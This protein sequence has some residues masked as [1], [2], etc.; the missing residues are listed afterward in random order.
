MKIKSTKILLKLFNGKLRNATHFAWSSMITFYLYFASLLF[1]DDITSIMFSVL[2]AIFIGFLKE[3]F[4]EI[5]LIETMI[6][7]ILGAVS[8]GIFILILNTI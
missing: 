7:N 5:F 2:I 4:D 8:T 6:Y 1:F 3:V